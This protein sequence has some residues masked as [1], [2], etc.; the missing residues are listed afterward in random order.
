MERTKAFPKNIEFDVMLTFK[1]TPKGYNIRSVTPDASLITV[2]QHHSFVELPD[3]NY[4][5]RKEL[6][7]SLK[8]MLV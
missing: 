8:V 4:K 7:K 2:H 1:G 3:N 6:A 5:P